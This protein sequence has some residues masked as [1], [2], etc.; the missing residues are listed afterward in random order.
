MSCSFGED[1]GH[2]CRAKRLFNSQWGM[3]KKHEPIRQAM[4]DDCENKPDR[5]VQVHRGLGHSEDSI[6]AFLHA[7]GH[8]TAVIMEAMK[9]SPSQSQTVE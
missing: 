4:H 8:S 1:K 7:K 2:I 9:R 5:I 6:I 3:C